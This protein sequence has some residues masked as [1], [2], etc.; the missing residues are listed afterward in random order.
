MPQFT[1]GR[2]GIMLTRMFWSQKL[3]ACL[4]SLFLMKVQSESKTLEVEAEHVCWKVVC[5]R[6]QKIMSIDSR[7]RPA[8]WRG[9]EADGNV[10]QKA[11]CRRYIVTTGIWCPNKVFTCK[12]TVF[13]WICIIG[14]IQSIQYL[15]LF[16]LVPEWPREVI[17]LCFVNKMWFEYRWFYYEFY[18]VTNFNLLV[19]PMCKFDFTKCV[20]IGIYYYYSFFIYRGLICAF[21]F[22]IFQRKLLECSDLPFYDYIKFHF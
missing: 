17:L 8:S 21:R 11:A 18:N 7:I 12:L 22:K 1:L 4:L 2:G 19:F 3:G 15:F 16:L 9:R 20:Q 5:E 10:R 14:L 6:W 13:P